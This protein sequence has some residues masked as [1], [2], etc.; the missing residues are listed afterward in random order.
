MHEISELTE[1]EYLQNWSETKGKMKAMDGQTTFS[2]GAPLTAWIACSLIS[3][4]Y[5]TANFIRKK[6]VLANP[7]KYICENFILENLPPQN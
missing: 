2:A 7:R 4:D 3:G 5:L 6:I 1:S